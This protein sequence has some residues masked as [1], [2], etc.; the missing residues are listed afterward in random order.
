M[1]D[2][3]LTLQAHPGSTLDAS[4]EAFL[5][6]RE[7][8]RCTPKTLQHY[9]YTCGSFINW[10]KCQ[11]VTDPLA[12]SA[13][14]IRTYLVSLQRRGLRDTTQHAHARGVKAWLNWLVDEEYLDTSP[15]RKV[16]MPKLE[17]RVLPPFAPE[18][19]GKLLSVCDRRTAIGTR[20][21]AIIL[22]LLDT[23]LRASEFLLLY[24]GEI[25]M[26]SGLVTIL[27]KGRKQRTVRVGSR[28]RSAVLLMLGHRSRVADGEALWIAY[29]AGGQERGALS[30]DGLRSV[31]KRLGAKAGVK[32]CSAHRFRRTFAL[33]CLRDGMDL[34]S[35]RM[36]MG[37]SSLAVLQRYLALAGEDLER[38]HIAHS[39]VDRLL[40]GT[41]AGNKE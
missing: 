6:G 18:E 20:D 7:A 5:L 28:A 35:L 22:T 24:M 4:L 9:R 8:A 14:H 23:G 13:H 36:L 3:P 33:W 17:E 32:P 11:G 27:G 39:P 29:N 34:H 19:V 37:H 15:M 1:S 21:Y 25:N 16:R 40:T 41:Q 12:I 30:L 26:R 2:E 31:L 38:A 10:L